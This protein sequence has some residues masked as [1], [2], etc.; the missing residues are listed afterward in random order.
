M[1]METRVQTALEKHRSGYNCAQAVLCTYAD[2]FGLNE[3]DAYKIAEGFGT[4]MG[5][6]GETC[7][8]VTAAFMLIGLKNS[9]GELG[10]K[11]TRPDTYKQIRELAE[12]FKAEAGSITC[13]ELKGATGLPVYPCPKCVETAARLVEKYLKSNG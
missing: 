5:G 3:R 12:S 9:N 7:G 10:N 8:A 4:G 13:H 2:A 1:Q 6:M 11:A